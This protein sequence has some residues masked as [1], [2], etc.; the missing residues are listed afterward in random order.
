M[1][2]QKAWL[3]IIK[4]YEK[5][6][7][8][9]SNGKAYPY[10]GAADK[11]ADPHKRWPFTCGYGH[12]MSAHEEEVGI[13]VNNQQ[14]NVMVEGL[15]LSLCDDL[16]AQDLAPRIVTVGN[17]LKNLSANEFG[18][19]LD[20]LYNCGPGALTNTP[21]TNHKLGK[22][23]EAAESMLLYRKAN[24]I[25]LLGLWRRRLTDAIF[26]LSGELLLA[27]DDQSTQAAINKLSTLLNKTIK[28][29]N[30]LH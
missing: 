29:P 3:E 7:P 26:Y 5:L 2:Y 28:M 27:D 21:G 30:G 18:A 15:S 9:V 19:F 25:A 4:G 8:N 14:I 20:I 13:R 6:G 1:T 23:L 16:L 11:P 17:K 12:L 10:Q 24:G 22:K